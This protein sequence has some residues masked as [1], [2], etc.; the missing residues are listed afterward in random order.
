M[1]E[2]HFLK[3]KL[4]VIGI[5]TMFIFS[6]LSVSGLITFNSITQFNSSNRTYND[7]E[8]IK[9]SNELNSIYPVIENPNQ[10][11]FFPN[12]QSNVFFLGYN[13]NKLNFKVSIPDIKIED[14]I[15]GKEKNLYQRVK[16][17]GEGYYEQSGYPRIP[18]ESMKI[19]IPLGKG[20]ESVQVIKGEQVTL[21]GNYKIEPVQ[22]QNPI[23]S[24]ELQKFSLNEEIYNSD[25]IFPKNDYLKVGSYYY[26]GYQIL[27]LNIFPVQYVPK[28][29]VISYYKDLEIS[30]NLKDT[31]EINPLFRENKKEKDQNYLRQI[32]NNPQIIS[33]NSLPLIENNV[34]S[35]NYSPLIDSTLS[36]DYVIITSEDLN[37][38]S[39]TYTFQ[40]LV[41][42]K[43]AQNI[44]TTIVTVESINTNYSGDDLQEKIRNFIKDAYLNW[45][46]EYVLLG[47]DADGENLGGESENAII[48][49]RG[50]YVNFADVFIDENIPSDLYYAALDGTWDNDGD[51]FWGE[52]GED[53]LLA[54]VYV[55]RAPID[56]EEE[57]SNFIMKTIAH[58][59]SEEPY[60]Y[61][62][63]I[64]G[65]DLG[66]PVWGADYMD[67][68]IYGSD[69][70]NYSTVGIEEEYL[71][72][73][74]YDRDLSPSYWEKEDI[75]P[76][77][78]EGVHVI[79]HLGHSDVA[80]NMKMVNEDVDSLTN[81]NY[82]FVYSQGCY[83][84][85]FDNRGVNPDGYFD[86][87]SI[88]EHFVTTPHGAFACVG[89]SRYG[90]GADNT[91]GAS[92]HY[93]REFYD[94][95]YG[96]GIEEIGKA[97]Q[98]SKED[99]IG[100]LSPDNPMRW[101]FYEA[102]LFGDPTASII[103][104]PLEHDISVSI[105]IPKN[106]DV[107]SSHE[108]NA[109]VKNRGLNSETS[110]NLTLFVE[111]IAVNSTLVDLN[112]NENAT[113]NFNWTAYDFKV[114]NFTANASIVLGEVL[115]E[116][117]FKTRFLEVFDVNNYDMSV[118]SYFWYDAY[119]N[120]IN[121]NISGDD[122][123][124]SV[125]L[126]SQFYFYDQVFSSIYI[127]SNGWLSFEGRSLYEFYNP[128]FPTSNY[129]YVIS[130]FWSD[131]QADNN[132]YAWITE[133]YTVI[134]YH[135]Y[136]YL[137]GDYIGT[138]EV[139]FF[140]TGD[141]LFQYKNIA[142]ELY[143]ATVG[144]NYG[145]NIGYYNAYTNG[146]TN[147]SEFALSFTLSLPDRH[148]IKAILS[149][150]LVPTYN[151]LNVINATVRNAGIY[152][153][154][155]VNLSLF[156]NDTL[157][158]T[159]TVDLDPGETAVIQYPWTPTDYNVYNFTAKASPVGDETLLGNNEVT[160]L[161]K[162]RHFFI[163]EPISDQFVNGSTAYVSFDSN[164]DLNQ[165]YVINI[166]VNEEFI[167]QIFGNEE[168]HDVFIPVFQNGTNLITFQAFWQDGAITNASV[169]IISEKVEP[170]ILP[171]I[172]DYI[173]FIIEE[174]G[175]MMGQRY[176]MVFDQWISDV[177]I[178]VSLNYQAIVDGEMLFEEEYWMYVNILNGYVSDGD[179][180][181][182]YTHFPFFTDL[183]EM[184]QPPSEDSPEIKAV[185]N[186]WND[187]LT[188]D[189]NI[190]WRGHEFLTL[191]SMSGAN[192]YVYESNNLLAYMGIN[193]DVNGFIRD[194]SFMDIASPNIPLLDDISY[195]YGATGNKITWEP[196]D[197]NP[198]SYIVYQ[199]GI[200]IDSD[201]W[202]SEI[203]IEINVDGF[204]VGT[205]EFNLT[206]WDIYSLIS[207]DIVIVRVTNPIPPVISHPDDISYEKNTENNNITWIPRD[208]NPNTY[209]ITIDGIKVDSG[210]WISREPIMINIDG[211]SEGTYNYTIVVSDLLGYIASDSVIVT[212]T[213]SSI[214]G[215]SIEFMVISL[216]VAISLKVGY[217]L[218]KI[219]KKRI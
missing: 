124:G 69:L 96:E 139:V 9:F 100:F 167:T 142:N 82:S 115:P 2:L 180:F 19:L 179:F 185:L 102:N 122:V 75:I 98:D 93:N 195:E 160:K 59:L 62:A 112:V 51:G 110:V 94:A 22:M 28:T 188:V 218:K 35:A 191:T 1:N 181:W 125:N 193:Y 32:V 73:T 219:K 113:I 31:N 70:Y 116:N 14:C 23:G 154:S 84:G 67:E 99:S 203:P 111:N 20:V 81:E 4:G 80:Y 151:V 187:F 49:S 65:E 156:V 58:E 217:S 106:A 12:K 87:D 72:E 189:G 168:I 196:T 97:N 129:N 197:I 158:D 171:H 143:N 199:D 13:D 194:T 161:L 7:T 170:I 169:S 53:D 25:D 48:P 216:G 56:S 147:V 202:T 11:E 140:K 119:Q 29:G 6:I 213:S 104:P 26:R 128:M 121:L 118:D 205:Y 54:E 157:Y 132:I 211:L 165:L 162:C 178:R 201:T 101:C 133:D 204:A 79:N 66:W 184:E 114:F 183:S 145:K 123:Y 57:L 155:N 5:L 135:D 177:E 37:S 92:Q 150:P 46:I 21:E 83:N 15:V 103:P 198:D 164:F 214:P 105:E 76:I 182:T 152:F 18:F 136:E 30:V 55:G 88:A 40:D 36:Y 176:Y 42:L 141:I 190:T 207:T 16:I 186:S 107:F 134:E 61:K 206:I 24:K 163:T 173:D 159:I 174:S 166:F 50:F 146:L 89:N 34:K 138:F 3:R 130:P 78:N 210:T 8:N 175:F 192:V 172:G 41:D 137:L 17:D 208:S 90:W 148:D 63:L 33:T 45:G 91:D 209:V 64:V 85:A 43:K 109:T 44:N 120:G 86:Y 27:F 149:T 215:Y 39:G 74:L 38:S 117:N 71:I 153:E 52:P 212:V 68:I 144:L 108:I 60:L 10:D 77:I 131:L 126:N 95:I 200:E 127:S 47:G